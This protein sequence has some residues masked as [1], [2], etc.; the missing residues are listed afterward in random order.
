MITSEVVLSETRPASPLSIKSYRASS[1][2]IVAAAARSGARLPSSPS[3]Q[4]FD[5]TRYE[6]P[7]DRTLDRYLRSAGQ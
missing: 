4:K 7:G 6:F 3:R 2:E 1:R 5:T